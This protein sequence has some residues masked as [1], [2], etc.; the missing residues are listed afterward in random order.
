[1]TNQNRLSEEINKRLSNDKWN[2]VIAS[3]VVS[4]KK[5]ITIKRNSFLILGIAILSFL[6]TINSSYIDNVENYLSFN[7]DEIFV[8]FDIMPELSLFTSE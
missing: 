4:E 1:M 8:T 7:E 2:D 3:N 6:I 5:W